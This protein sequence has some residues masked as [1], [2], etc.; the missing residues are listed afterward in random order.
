[1]RGWGGCFGCRL[2]LVW[3]PGHCE[4]RKTTL[5]QCTIFTLTWNV[6]CFSGTTAKRRG[7]ERGRER[8]REREREGEKGKEQT[9]RQLYASHHMLYEPS[10]EIKIKGKYT[11]THSCTHTHTRAHSY[12]DKQHEQH[13]QQQQLASHMVEMQFLTFLRHVRKCAIKRWKFALVSACSGCQGERGI[14]G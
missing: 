10:W 6:K 2:G 8:V 5:H 7:A 14:E 1:M 12:V 9:E 11:H 4:K 13:E 3:F